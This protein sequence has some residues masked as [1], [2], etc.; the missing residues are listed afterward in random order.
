[1]ATR[2]WEQRTTVVR[3]SVLSPSRPTSTFLALLLTNASD[4]KYEKKTLVTTY[5]SES[6]CFMIGVSDSFA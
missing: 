3:A 6:D 4:E 2:P 5:L 1:M